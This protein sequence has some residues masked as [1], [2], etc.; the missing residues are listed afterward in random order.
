MPRRRHPPPLL[1][2]ATDI[3]EA[4]L[5][6]PLLHHSTTR[7]PSPFPADALLVTD[8]LGHTRPA[9]EGEILTAAPALLARRVRRGRP[10]SS[11][12]HTRDY[13]RLALA[14]LDHEVFAILFLDNR[15]RVIEFVPLFR[16]TVDGASVHP[17]EVVKEALARNAAA[18]ILAHN[19]PSGIA[20]PSSAD[21]LIT[22][23]IRDALSLVDI[24]VL[25][26][27]VVT[28]DAI[29]SF[30]ERGLI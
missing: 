4:A 25:D 14:P 28:G 2:P 8:R 27:F 21:E 9:T 15:H 26:H 10:L 13:L 6:L 17:R 19:H 3:A 5:Q 29:V 20:E 11:P 12:R 23:R 16:G 1:P 24:R 7:F 22:T 18:V 30:A